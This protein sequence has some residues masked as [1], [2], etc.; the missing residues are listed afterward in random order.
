VTDP[1]ALPTAKQNVP[2]FT[3][4][5]GAWKPETCSLSAYAGQ[6]VLLAFRTFNDPGTLGVDPPAPI[7]AGAWVDDVKVGGTLIS[8]G[9]S[10]DGWQSFTQVHPNS[11]AGFTVT[12]LSIETAK[13]KITVKQLPL[14]GDF[15][16]HGQANVQKYIEKNA[17][18]VAAIVF[19][20]DPTETSTDYARY[21]LT[22]NGVTQP[23]GGM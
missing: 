14:T 7:P 21:R 12:I 13:G 8:D 3:G 20:D 22:V 19:Y 9:S 10:L 15:D 18:F 1:G 17:D 16:V 2:G 6:T 4:F 5:P 11:V 23:G